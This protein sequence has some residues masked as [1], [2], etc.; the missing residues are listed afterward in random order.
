[1]TRITIPVRR[2][3][4]VR[5]RTIEFDVYGHVSA[6]TDAIIIN[7]PGYNGHID[8]YG[9]KYRKLGESISARNIAAFVRAPNLQHD[10]EPY[11]RSLVLDVFAVCRA[12]REHALALTRRLRPDFYLMGFSAGGGAVAAAANAKDVRK[13]LLLAPS[14]D[15]DSAAIRSG[16]DYYR[17]ELYVAVGEDD[18]VVP[19]P[20]ARNFVADA[21]QASVKHFV[22]IPD[23]DHQFRG[24]KNGKILSKAPL[25]AFCGDTS[26]PDPSGGIELY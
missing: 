24:T 1:M 15:A 11:K 9:D 21:W 10:G 26:F 12:V 19:P 4:L 3:S 20:V 18:D 25:W 13:I 2:K 16:L 7:V 14:Y 22:V 23:C 17:G 8:G 6:G 5:G